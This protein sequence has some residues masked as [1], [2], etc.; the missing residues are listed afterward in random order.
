MREVAELIESY[1]GDIRVT[2]RQ[3]FILTGIP[4]ERLD[5]VIGRVGEIGFPV[6][7]QRSLRVIDRMYRRPPLQLRGDPDQRPSSRPSSSGWSAISATRSRISKSISTDVPTRARSIGLAISVCRERPGADPTVEPLEAFRHHP[8]RW[9]RART[10][11]SASR[12]CAECRR[13]WSKIT[14][15]RLVAGYLHAGCPTRLSRTFACGRRTRSLIGMTHDT[16]DATPR[17][18]GGVM[19]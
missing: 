18:G 8:A 14:V 6:E 1:G 15:S 11:R 2:R 19:L 5:D 13:R 4:R 3:N 17:R 12:S 9:T 16:A 7:R 10:P